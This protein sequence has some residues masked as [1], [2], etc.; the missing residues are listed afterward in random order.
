MRKNRC[1]FQFSR[2]LSK[3]NEALLPDDPMKAVSCEAV[4]LKICE[5]FLAAMLT[6]VNSAVKMRPQ[7]DGITY[8]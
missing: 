1:G 6:I 5:P 4:V 7:P 8:D 2:E 3:L